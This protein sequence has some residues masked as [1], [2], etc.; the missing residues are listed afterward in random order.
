MPNATARLHR[1]SQPRPVAA[2]PAADRRP[3]RGTVALAILALAACGVFAPSARAGDEASVERGRYLVR[4]S[5]CNDCHTA[6]Y[7]E[8]AGH[9]AEAT[10]L[11]GTPVGFHGPWGTTYASNLRLLAA[12]M[13][14]AAWLARARQ[15]MRPPMPWFALRDMRDDDVRSIYRYLRVAGPAGTPA[16]DYV[17]PTRKPSGPVIV[18]VPAPLP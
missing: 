5:G 13:D 6:G 8:Q 3:T 7:A 4:T 2:R 18:F 14:E 17:P 11:T 12:G 9:V 16:P 10:W 15:P 1:P